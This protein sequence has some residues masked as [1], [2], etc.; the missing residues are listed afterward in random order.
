MS[1]FPVTIQQR[2]STV[3]NPFAV[4]RRPLKSHKQID[5]DYV[6]VK[7]LFRVG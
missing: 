4:L 2:K 6:Y 1:N 7:L 3:R 5:K